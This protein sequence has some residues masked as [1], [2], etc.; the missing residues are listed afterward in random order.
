V[1][2]VDD[3]PLALEMTRRALESGGFAVITASTIA[4]LE[5]AIAR[6]A[7]DL[8]LVDVNMP[9]MYG[10]DVA[11]VLKQVRGVAIPIWLFSSELEADLADRLK[12][13]KADG[14]ISKSSGMEAVVDRVRS[15]L[16][17]ES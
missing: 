17:R 12:A 16:R 10:D 11:M 5:A 3:S 7:P 15:I 2:I 8:L 14:F 9:E 1:A 4:E 13:A 6:S